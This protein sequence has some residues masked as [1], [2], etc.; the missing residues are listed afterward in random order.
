MLRINNLKY[1]IKAYV[2]DSMLLDYAKKQ[3]CLKLKL[4]DSE[5][6]ELKLLRKNIDARQNIA[7]IFHISFGLYNREKEQI[8]LRKYHFVEKYTP[9]NLNV[10]KV[11]NKKK[12]LVVGMGP[13]GLFC[14]YILSKSGL[15]VSIIDRGKKVEERL[16]DVDN[17][18]KT[19]KLNQNSNI[20]FGEGGAG[21][22]S[23][24]K[25]NTGNHT[26]L[27]EAV[28]KLFVEHG[29]P[30]NIMYEAK[31]HIG[32]DVLQNVLKNIRKT[33]EQQNVKVYFETKL[34]NFKE[35]SDGIVANFE[36]SVLKTE[37]YDGM[38]LAIGH[39]ATDTYEMLYNN[40]VEMNP[41]AF[42]IGFR[43]EHLQK[44]ISEALYHDKAK[45]LP[46]ASYKLVTHLASSRAAYTFC[47]CPGGYVVN[48]S[49]ENEHLVVNGMS[50][51]A[52]DGI[53][54]NSAVLVEIKP[55]DYYVNSPLDGLNFQRMIEK[56]CY[57]VGKDYGVPVQRYIDFKNNQ[58]TKEIGKITPTIKPR[59]IY[60]NINDIL[61]K[62]INDSLK[63]AIEAF[64][65]KINGFNCD[66][67]IL[68]IPETRS[69]S[70]IQI[71][72]NEKYL[73]TKYIYPIGEGAGFSGGIMTSAI[74]GI[75]CALKII[76]EINRGE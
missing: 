76:E 40:N 60:A 67:A 48:A 73:A 63:E 58:I 72:R 74:D 47:M 24:G 59:Y 65:L 23:D 30:S 43:I 46:P 36:S 26:E 33:L 7:Y 20:Q 21:T 19:G 66:D 6:K 4:K 69:S 18:F 12:Y 32:T 16:L 53:N 49:S 10:P 25:L 31:P 70:P 38:I 13:A 75:K 62:W 15:D 54:A 64:S 50:N 17:F 57:N 2:T 51:F 71:K 56:K 3:I 28:L 34:T 35:E 37:K 55:S 9:F 44:D 42:A 22:F 41:K 39:S 52:R 61:P 68:T 45:Y 11:K 14:A 29:A 1:D 8:L 27:V 5:I